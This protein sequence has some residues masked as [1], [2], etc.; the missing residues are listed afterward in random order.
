VEKESFIDGVL[1]HSQSSTTFSLDSSIISIQD[2]NAWYG[3]TQAL[4]QVNLKIYKNQITAFIG[5]SGCG[6]TTLL[7]CLNRMNDLIP[8]FDLKGSIELQ[9]ENI[10]APGYSVNKLRKQVGMVFQQA[11]PFPQT[12]LNNLKLPLEENFRKLGKAQLKQIAIDKLKDTGL[13]EEVKDR[14]QQSALKL[15]GGQQQRLCVAR[16]LAIDPEILLLDEP[17]SALDP[18]S[19]SKIEALLIRLK[20]RYSIVIVTHNLQQAA[21]IADY[22]VFFYQGEIVEQGLPQ[23]IFITPRMKLT[24]QYLQ[25]MF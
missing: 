5:P 24:S 17:C 1:V 23:E 4:K 18:I 12:V 6:K 20:E 7:R 9:G 15:S 8:G 21:R 19:T 25:G 22:V 16:A 10:Y 2:L 14:L 11:N 13:L 3:Q